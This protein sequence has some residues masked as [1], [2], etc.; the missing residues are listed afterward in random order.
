MKNQ[1]TL[2]DKKLTE[3]R[4][5]VELSEFDESRTKQSFRDECDINKIMDRFAKT[6]VLP[7]LEG[8]PKYIDCTK[9]VDFQMMHEASAR[10]KE[11]FNGL[12]PEIKT[13]LGT[14]ER[15]IEISSQMTDE[16]INELLNTTNNNQTINNEKEV[17]KHRKSK[18]DS[19]SDSSPSGAD[20]AA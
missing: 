6:G 4:K 17:E 7:N 1:G 11:F 10:A 15:F 13:K 9:I 5:V 16:Q 20:R 12:P 19:N 8:T 18:M 2:E 3:N 14:A